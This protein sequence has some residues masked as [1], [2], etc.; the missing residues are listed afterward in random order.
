MTKL[1][2]KHRHSRRR[3]THRRH[4]D[5]PRDPLIPGVLFVH[6]W[7]WRSGE[8]LTR[9]RELAALGCV[10][11]TFDLRGHAQ[12]EL[13]FDTVTREDSIRDLLA[14]YD[15]LNGNPWSTSHQLPWWAAA[16]ARISPRS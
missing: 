9:A 12:T 8:Y 4:A 13:Q 10:C 11:L 14:A 5:H 16:T 6:G 7:G 2:E 15:L 1:D 3:R